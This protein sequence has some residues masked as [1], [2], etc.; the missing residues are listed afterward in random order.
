MVSMWCSLCYMVQ[1]DFLCLSSLCIQEGRLIFGKNMCYTL[2]AFGGLESNYQLIVIHDTFVRVFH[3]TVTCSW[4][5]KFLL[6]YIT[7]FLLYCSPRLMC[8][9]QCSF[10][11]V[12]HW[13][14]KQIFLSLTVSGEKRD[15]KS[16]VYSWNVLWLK[17]YTCM[18]HVHLIV[19][20]GER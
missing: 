20:F 6:F 1:C 10:A 11:V 2:T 5:V 15:L 13:E 19:W 18:L 14:N 16:I 9:G 8:Q 4:K 17:C 3:I 12:V 7:M